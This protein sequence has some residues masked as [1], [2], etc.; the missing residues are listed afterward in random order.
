M[1]VGVGIGMAV[2]ATGARVEQANTRNSANKKA[3]RFRKIIFTSILWMIVAMWV[4][5]WRL[6]IA[7]TGRGFDLST[8]WLAVMSATILPKDD[9]APEIAGQLVKF[10]L[11]RHRL[12]EI[13]QEISE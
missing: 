4:G 1:G 12:I 6:V 7:R 11:K 5:A 13:G 2:G 8:T 9:A 10:L 3:I